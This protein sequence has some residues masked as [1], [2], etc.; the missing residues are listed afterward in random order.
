MTD[1]K[2][3]DLFFK[4]DEQAIQMSMDTYDTYC[5]TVASGIFI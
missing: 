2:I 1:E 4:R 5:R 3:I